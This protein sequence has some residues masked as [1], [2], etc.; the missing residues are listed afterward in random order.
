MFINE[1]ETRIAQGSNVHRLVA[2][3]PTQHIIGHFGDDQTS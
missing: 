3:R 1:L 2:Q